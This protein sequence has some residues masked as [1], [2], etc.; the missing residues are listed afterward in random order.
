[1]AK[2]ARQGDSPTPPP[3]R[4]AGG[5]AADPDWQAGVT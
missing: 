4:H 2:P 3:Q 1:M 5:A